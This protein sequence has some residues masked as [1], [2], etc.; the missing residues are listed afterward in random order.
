MSV[1]TRN[2][3]FSITL[4]GFLAPL[5]VANPDGTIADTDRA[6]LRALYAGISIEALIW[7]PVTAS[8]DTWT[9]VTADSGVWSNVTPDSGSWMNV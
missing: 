8:S 6:Q 7:T 2:K 5:L 1:D 3:R 4:L 9:N